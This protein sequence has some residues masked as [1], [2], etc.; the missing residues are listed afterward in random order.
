[1]YDKTGLKVETAQCVRENFVRNNLL[2]LERNIAA[3]PKRI[4]AIYLPQCTKAIYAIGFSQR[5]FLRLES[6]FSKL[7]TFIPE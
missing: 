3:H 6:Y 4:L 2:L 1:M 7:R 5:A